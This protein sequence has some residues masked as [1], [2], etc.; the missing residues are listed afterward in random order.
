[1]GINAVFLGATLGAGIL[2]SV[3]GIRT[4]SNYRLDDTARK[5]GFWPLNA[6]LILSAV[7]IYLF[8]AAGP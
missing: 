7:S 5:K 4:L 2:L 6:G 1:M 3:M 8:A